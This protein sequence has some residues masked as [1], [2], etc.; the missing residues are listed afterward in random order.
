MLYSWSVLMGLSDEGEV[1]ISF[2]SF[3]VSLLLYSA[4]VFSSR[5]SLDTVYYC[6]LLLGQLLLQLVQIAAGGWPVRGPTRPESSTTFNSLPVTARSSQRE[7]VQ[8]P[9]KPT[10]RKMSKGEKQHHMVMMVPPPPTAP[11]PVQ[12]FNMMAPPSYGEAVSGPVPLAGPTVTAPVI[13]KPLGVVPGMEFGS[14][15]VQ[16]SCWSC[17]RQVT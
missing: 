6:T 7:T 4:E 17:H 16:L 2:D 15:P 9:F 13:Q 12:Q 8:H 5:E 3:D 10:P 1:I 14:E 11:P